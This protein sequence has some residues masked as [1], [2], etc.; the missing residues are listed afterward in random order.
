[1]QHLMKLALQKNW[2]LLV[3][4]GIINIRRYINKYWSE[5]GATLFVCFNYSN[6]VQKLIYVTNVIEGFAQQFRKVIK[7]KTV[8]PSHD[9]VSEMIYLATI[10]I[11]KNV[12]DATGTDFRYEPSWKFILKNGK[13]IVANMDKNRYNSCKQYT[14]RRR[15]YGICKTTVVD[16]LF[17]KMGYGMHIHQI[18]WTKHYL[19]YK[20]TKGYQSLYTAILEDVEL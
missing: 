19:K 16:T 3:K 7:S 6:E 15:L 13:K 5:Y 18:Q 4:N 10:Y 17:T 11:T 2:N 14:E 12:P 8:F 1:M 20:D 9:S